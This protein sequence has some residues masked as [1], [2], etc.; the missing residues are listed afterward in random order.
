MK[1]VDASALA[2]ILFTE[3]ESADVLAALGDAPLA[4]PALIDLELASVCLKKCRRLPERRHDFL[5]AFALLS[6][7]E[8]RRVAVPAPAV[9]AIALDARLSAYD[10][11]YLWLARHLGAPLV[12]L[13]ARL[14]AAAA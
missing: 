12:T 6:R 7:F 1:V 9:L 3:A 2:A 8:L 14:A 5:A 13:D 10:A 11:A 4:A